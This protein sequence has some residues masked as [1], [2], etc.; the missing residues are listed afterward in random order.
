[1]AFAFR[2]LFLLAADL[3]LA[4]ALSCF[5][6]AFVCLCIA[7]LTCFV[8]VVSLGIMKK[9]E[10]NIDIK[11][12]A[13]V[14]LMSNSSIGRTFARNLDEAG[15]RVTTACWPPER[16]WAKVLKRECSPN[17]KMAQLHI[18]EDEYKMTL[19]TLIE[20]HLSLKGMY[21]LMKKPSV[22][23]WEEQEPETNKLSEEKTTCIWKNVR[24]TPAGKE[25]C[26]MTQHVKNATMKKSH[27]ME[28][29]GKELIDS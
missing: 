19:K 2:Q 13:I 17:T 25:T 3:M 12:R 26:G 28:Q 11:G 23:M 21:G 24:I 8:I 6:Y 7:F 1:M 29:L 5:L 4:L 10:R 18:S 22:L 16:N 20:K 9:M 27:S 15:F 14:I